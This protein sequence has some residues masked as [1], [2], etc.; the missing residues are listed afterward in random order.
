MAVSA[1]CFPN[2]WNLFWNISQTNLL[3]LQKSFFF[4]ATYFGILGLCFVPFSVILPYFF[5]SFVF[6]YFLHFIT[7]LFLMLVLSTYIQN[8]NWGI[9][10]YNLLCN[11]HL[12]C[13][14][15]FLLFVILW[16]LPLCQREALEVP[17]HQFYPI[18]SYGHTLK[19]LF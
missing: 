6:L 7:A 1:I 11:S 2:H 8:I 15:L 13:L 12:V 14:V 17:K 19:H 10:R 18:F 4:A 16:F 3:Q 5:F 9:N